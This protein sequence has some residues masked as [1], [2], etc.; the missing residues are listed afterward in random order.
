MKVLIVGILACMTG[1]AHA[2]P[3]AVFPVTIAEAPLPLDPLPFVPPPSVPVVKAATGGIYD[4]PIA[5]EQDT[6]EVPCGHEMTVKLGKLDVN[7]PHG[8][9]LD[10][11]GIKGSTEA[12]H[13]ILEGIEFT[14]RDY[15]QK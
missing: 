13:V 10:I 7:M 4:S 5:I 3:P 2:A 14:T 1:C 12:Y 11:A 15:C 6:K 9:K 8:G